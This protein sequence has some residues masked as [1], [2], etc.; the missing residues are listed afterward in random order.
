[1]SEQST[2]PKDKIGQQKPSMHLIP[3]MP[4]ME[5]AMVM[6]LGADKYGPYNW[7]DSSVSASVYI[8]AAYRH[9]ASWFDGED[10]DPESGQ[11]HLAHARACLGILM[12]CV[13]Q[14]TVVDD[15]PIP[16]GTAECI[17]GVNTSA[18]AMHTSPTFNGAT[19]P[20]AP[21]L[22]YEMPPVLNFAMNP[23]KVVDN[24]PNV[25][26]PDTRSYKLTQPETDVLERHLIDRGVPEEVSDLI[27]GGCR[28]PN[29]GVIAG[30]KYEDPLFTKPTVYVAGPMRGYDKFNFPAFDE[31][32][33]R[34]LKM[35]WAT[36]SPA[37]IDRGAGIMGEESIEK[38]QEYNTSAAARDFAL[39]DF[40]AL[41]CLRGEHG[42]AIAM[43][44]GW[45]DS[46]GAR[47]EFFLAQWLGLKILDAE[48]GRPM[49]GT[50][51]IVAHSNND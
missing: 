47:A 40:Y 16:G 19:L 44:P 37:D 2:N 15:R 3:S 49:E 22:S 46:R 10:I 20:C 9:I 25:C 41:H 39:R 12:D 48:T 21:I 42:D 36:I 28:V 14:G 7:R 23:V 50:Q 27:A 33:N 30:M 34:F 18:P 1:M 4:L 29:D 38:Q 43:L 45:Q 26:Y 35:G 31:A 24:T 32:R 51:L 8:S 5:E 11:S 17:R 13:N 6:K